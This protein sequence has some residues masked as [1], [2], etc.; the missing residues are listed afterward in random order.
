MSFGRLDE[1]QRRS[2]RSAPLDQAAQLIEAGGGLTFF[3]LSQT[4]RTLTSGLV[5]GPYYIFP[6]GVRVGYTAEAR[7]T[8]MDTF[9]SFRFPT[10]YG[11]TTRTSEVSVENWQVMI[12][13]NVH[14]PV[15]FK[16]SAL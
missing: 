16:G 2:D 5:Q 15:L 6:V 8:M 9:V 14:S 1:R 4:I 3:D 10:L 13:F 7:A 12:G 11:F